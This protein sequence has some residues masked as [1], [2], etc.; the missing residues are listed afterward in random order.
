MTTADNNNNNAPTPTP[1]GQEII[2]AGTRTL[3]LPSYN[4]DA[5]AQ[6]LEDVAELSCGNDAGEDRS[7]NQTGGLFNKRNKI[8][9]GSGIGGI[10]LV[11]VSGLSSASLTSNSN[12]N[13][14]VES[15]NVQSNANFDYFSLVEPHAFPSDKGK[16]LGGGSIVDDEL[17]IVVNSFSSDAYLAS[18]P[19]LR[20]CKLLTR[21]LHS[22]DVLVLL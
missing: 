19:V 18:V 16:K 22:L 14:V 9:V 10:L 12:N 13:M 7:S 17:L 8:I 1:T 15:F 11:F 5:Q 20:N 4:D 6:G 21:T 3:A 2:L